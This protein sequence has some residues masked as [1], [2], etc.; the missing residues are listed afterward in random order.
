MLAEKRREELAPLAANWAL[1]TA[2]GL[3]SA[4]EVDRIGIIAALGLA[5]KRA[6]VLL[7][8]LGAA[9]RE[10]T[11]LLDGSHD[12]LTPALASPLPVT[13]RIKADASC[14]SVAAASVV[15]KVH[16]DRLMIEADAVSPGY[17]WSG[18][19]GYGSAA[20]FEAI[21]RL[22]ATDLHRRTWLHAS[23]LSE[24]D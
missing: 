23:P 9:V 5:G 18:N 15:A 12:W 6:L 17:G 24:R 20:H 1:F 4:E 10:S 8:E 22:G 21:A 19:K 13:T 11:I 14:A 16:R 2:V 3:A 7:H